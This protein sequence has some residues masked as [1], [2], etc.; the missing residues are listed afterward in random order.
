ME[1][2]ELT[3]NHDVIFSSYPSFLIDVPPGINTDGPFQL[4]FFDGDGTVPLRK[5][6]PAPAQALVYS[7]R[8]TFIGGFFTPFHA[9]ANQ[10]YTARLVSGPPTKVDFAYSRKPQAIDLPATSGT[11]GYVYSGGDAKAN[12]AGFPATPG[13]NG[14]IDLP[15][16]S[17][18]LASMSV[19]TSDKIPAG[20]RTLGGTDIIPLPYYITLALRTGVIPDRAISLTLVL[21]LTS[22]FYHG[23]FNVALY[24]TRGGWRL[25]VADPAPRR[26]DVLRLKIRGSELSRLRQSGLY[27]LALYA[28]RSSGGPNAAAVPSGR[29]PIVAVVGDSISVLTILP[30]SPVIPPNSSCASGWPEPINCEYTA[31]STFSYPG[32]I[33]RLTGARLINLARPDNGQTTVGANAWL[34]NQVPYIP[35]DTDVVVFEGGRAD[36]IFGGNVDSSPRVAIMV[37]AILARAP[38]AK[39]VFLAPLCISGPIADAWVKAEQQLAPRYGV[40]VDSSTVSSCADI[41]QH[42]DGLHE[43]LLGNDVIGSKV[44]SAVNSLLSK[45]SNR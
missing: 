32:V 37:R 12:P 36:M 11:A 19:T 9:K 26:G 34:E 43:T 35:S 5:I 6:N 3:F 22:T 28:L 39:I 27:T 8:L 30:Q 29:R 14:A 7:G 40:F 13:V 15:A 31:D 17:T 20:V 33:A 42:T 16:S 44:A 2:L 4:N 21:P 10:V 45:P 18:D 24:D 41:L 23:Q 38:H 25:A 1:T